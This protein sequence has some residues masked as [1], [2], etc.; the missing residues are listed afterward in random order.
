MAAG[1]R[2]RPAS[3]GAHL[4]AGVSPRV[5]AATVGGHAAN[6]RR[7]RTGLNG[8]GGMASGVQGRVQRGVVG[9]RSG[10]YGK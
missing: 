2:E 6:A 4:A 5:V 7:E 3:R 8:C 9:G 10:R 1:E